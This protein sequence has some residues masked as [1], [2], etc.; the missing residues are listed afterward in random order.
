MIHD[1]RK[2][3]EELTLDEKVNAKR[4]Y[5]I[6]KGKSVTA[7]ITYKASDIEELREMFKFRTC[8][9]IRGIYTVL[10]H[11]K[12]VKYIYIPIPK[13]PRKGLSLL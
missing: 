3:Y 4:L 13:T 12:F 5:D 7:N 9:H 8:D 1:Y 10:K 6:A 2:Y 11:T